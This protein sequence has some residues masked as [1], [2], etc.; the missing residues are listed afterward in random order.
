MKRA[1]T[2]VPIAQRRNRTRAQDLLLV[3]TAAVA[4]VV[5]RNTGHPAVGIL[6]FDLVRPGVCQ[7]VIVVLGAV[8]CAHLPN[9]DVFDGPPGPVDFVRARSEIARP[10]NPRCWS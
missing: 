10:R 8:A 6:T 1:V 2:M 5:E 3:F 9:G 7:P 4:D